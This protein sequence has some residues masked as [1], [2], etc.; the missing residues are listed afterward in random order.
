ISLGF[1]VFV[2]LT[3]MIE[4]Y[5]GGSAIA[6]KNQMNLLRAMAELTHRNTRRY[7][8]YIVHMGIVLMFM[9]FTGAA[10]NQNEVAEVRAGKH[11]RIGPYDLRVIELK[12]GENDTYAWHRAVMEA[13]K[14]GS[15][16]GLMEPEKRFYKANR[17]GTHEVAVRQRP[18]EDLYLN[19][20]G[21]SD[22]NERAII[23]AYI[24]PLVSWIWIGGLVLIC[25]TLLC[26]GS[27]KGEMQDR[28]PQ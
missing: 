6:A 1:C 21:M 5:R 18:N 19:F 27:P 13:S 2:A 8:G 20:A 10:F 26:L 7:G 23:Q 4:F 14:N 9:G 25:G 3:V 24:F 11:M 15:V 16:L 12:Q 22:D 17:E 28:R